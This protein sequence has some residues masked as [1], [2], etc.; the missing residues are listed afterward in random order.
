[1]LYVEATDLHHMTHNFDLFPAE[2]SSS[3]DAAALRLPAL[4]S[5]TEQYDLV[6]YCDLCHSKLTM[7]TADSHLRANSHC[8][9]SLYEIPKV[10]KPLSLNSIPGPPIVSPCHIGKYIVHRKVRSDS[11][12]SVSP[13]VWQNHICVYH[14][15][16]LIMTFH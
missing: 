9:A 1:M 10:E 15:M 4:Q 6:L 3:A 5:D 14:S 7:E 8:S 2:S 13:M 16:G 12:L 11:T